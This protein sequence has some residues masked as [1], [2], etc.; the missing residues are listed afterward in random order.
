M[1]DADDDDAE[2]TLLAAMSWYQQLVAIVA[3][4]LVETKEERN[5]SLGIQKLNWDDY[6]AK[7]E[8]HPSFIKRH[9]CMSLESFYKLLGYIGHGLV[10]NESKAGKAGP[11]LPE[12]CLFCAL[13]WLAG[14]SYLDI[15]A[16]TGVSVSSFYR[17][18]YR[19]LRLIDN[20]EQLDIHLPQTLEECTVAAEG[21]RSVSFGHAI[22]NCIGAVDGYLL[23]IYTPPKNQAGNVK[24]FFS[25]HYQ[26]SGFNVQAMCDHH[27]RAQNWFY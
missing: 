20:C 24:S 8:G 25:G 9:I 22:V 3:T 5:P 27:S 10:V 23:R 18:V 21:F 13:R 26:V 19:C 2:A 11:I 12:I 17:V 6:V 1:D 7:F 14:G 15:F 4:V 16:L